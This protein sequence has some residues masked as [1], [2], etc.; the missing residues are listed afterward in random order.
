MKVC[1]GCLIILLRT[2]NPQKGLCNGTR[3]KVLDFC[4]YLLQCEIIQG[5]YAGTMVTIPRIYNKFDDETYPFAFKRKQFPVRL[6]YAISIHKS[7]GQT[8][9]RMGLYLP[10]P[11]FAHGM[12]YVALSRVGSPLEILTYIKKTPTQGICEN[13]CFT[14]NV[15]YKELLGT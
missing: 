2:L 13:G 3:L 11:V 15:V 4:K 12:L 9:K 5:P 8:L 14:R 6:A 1:K 7:Q 10:E